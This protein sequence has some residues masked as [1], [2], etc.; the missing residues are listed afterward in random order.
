MYV[1]LCRKLKSACKVNTYYYLHKINGGSFSN[2][3]F[4]LNFAGGTLAFG[5]GCFRW[6]LRCRFKR[7]SGRRVTRFFLNVRMKE[8]KRWM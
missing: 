6:R 2:S 4:F 3:Y 8:E 5:I 1:C 7:E